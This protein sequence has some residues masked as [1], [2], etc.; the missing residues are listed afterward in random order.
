MDEGLPCSSLRTSPPS[1]SFKPVS[2]TSTDLFLPMLA[3]KQPAK[4]TVSLD[5]QA[6]ATVGLRELDF[7]IEDNVIWPMSKA[8]SYRVKNPCIAGLLRVAP[9]KVLT[10]EIGTVEHPGRMP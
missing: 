5:T 7:S 8:L 10:K 4:F 9:M 6:A 1:R 3:K 2:T